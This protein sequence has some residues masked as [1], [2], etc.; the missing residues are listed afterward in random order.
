[1]FLVE[2]LCDAAVR[3][4]PVRADGLTR[5]TNDNIDGKKAAWLSTPFAF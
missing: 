2:S 1:V 4:V 3:K 5:A